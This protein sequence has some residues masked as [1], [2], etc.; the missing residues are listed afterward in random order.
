MQ[1]PNSVGLVFAVVFGGLHL[2]W[3]LIVLVGVGQPLYDFIMWAHMIHVP[4]IIGPFD[5]VASVILI[6][7]TAVI[8]YIL[9]NMV[10]RVWNHLHTA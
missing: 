9:G 4:I 5:L 7:V 6:I 10:A 2:L 1:N 3:S 8:G